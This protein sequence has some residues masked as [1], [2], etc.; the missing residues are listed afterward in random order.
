[1]LQRREKL[2]LSSFRG[3]VLPRFLESFC[4]LTELRRPVPKRSEANQSDSRASGVSARH[5]DLSL[6]VLRAIPA[7]V[8]KLESLEVLDLSWN[9]FRVDAPLDFLIEGCPLLLELRLPY[10]FAPFPHAQASKAKLLARNPD[11]KVFAP[12]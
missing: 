2:E 12:G 5:L 9:Y 4:A 1:M 7:F 10:Y 3:S 6:Y 8:G 11:A